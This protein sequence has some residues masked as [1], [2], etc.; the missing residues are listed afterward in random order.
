MGNSGRAG[1]FTRSFPS[2]SCLK[3]KKKSYFSRVLPYQTDLVRI[4]PRVKGDPQRDP[5]FLLFPQHLKYVDR[6][7]TGNPA[8]PARWKREREWVASM[9]AA[10]SLG[11]STKTP[12]QHGQREPL[13]FSP[14]LVLGVITGT[15]PGQRGLFQ[16]QVGHALSL[17]CQRPRGSSRGP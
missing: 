16:V 6:G 2:L 7:E 10:S 14:E 4:L 17:G 15:L 11:P 3:K 12:H 5:P 13:P 8:R 9:P 1:T